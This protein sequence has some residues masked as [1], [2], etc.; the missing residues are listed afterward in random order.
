MGRRI[1]AGSKIHL[2][3]VGGFNVSFATQ[4]L[5]DRHGTYTYGSSTFPIDA[6]DVSVQTTSYGFGGGADIVIG[7][8]SS[9]AFVGGARLL[10]FHRTMTQSYYDR[11]VPP[12]GS[13][14]V[15]IAA[16]VTLRPCR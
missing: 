2:H 15:H 8:S 12:M 4:R 6:P 14:V 3:P 5:M 1:R 11:S 10:W 7:T 16:G 13:Y 9:V